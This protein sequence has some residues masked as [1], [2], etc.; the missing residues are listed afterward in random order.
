MD[1]SRKQALRDAGV[2]VEEGLERFMN[3][4][5]LWE[6]FLSKFPA[7]PN[8]AALSAALDKGDWAAALAAAHSL[9]GVCGNLSFTQ[10][11]QLLTRQVE[12]L[13]AGDTDGALALRGPIEEGCAR[14][15][16]LL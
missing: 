5:A 15:T 16:Q 13:R 3:N 14:I 12:A 2:N 9:K 1:E 11:H 7:D 4:E 6:R 8:P 10:L